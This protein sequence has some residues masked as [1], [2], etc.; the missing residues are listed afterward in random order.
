MRTGIEETT[1]GDEWYYELDGRVHGPMMRSALEE[2]LGSSGETVA[3]VRIRKGRGNGLRFV[4]GR[5]R[6][7]SAPVTTAAVG[8]FDRPTAAGGAADSTEGVSKRSFFGIATSRR[9]SAFGFWPTCC[10]C[11][12]DPSPMRASGNTWRS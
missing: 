12:L 9:P 5:L 8:K 2:L 11:C 10:F 1:A 7:A 3:D 6:L 4:R